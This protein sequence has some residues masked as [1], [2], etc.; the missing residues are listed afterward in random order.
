[1]IALDTNVLSEFTHEVPNPRVAAWLNRQPMHTLY[2]PSVVMGELLHGVAILPEGK[3]KESLSRTVEEWLQKFEG[4][5]LP[6]DGGAARCYAVLAAKARSAGQPMGQN[7]AYIAAIAKVRGF[8]IATRD[9]R[10]FQAAGLEV[11]NPWE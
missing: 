7:D 8:A 9:V 2:V 10:P 1:M 4:R 5:I 6:L 11:I 3:R